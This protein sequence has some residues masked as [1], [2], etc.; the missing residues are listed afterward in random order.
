MLEAVVHGCGFPEV[1]GAYVVAADFFGS[2]DCDP[3]VVGRGDGCNA[4]EVEGAET[5]NT[6]LELEASLVK[7]VCSPNTMRLVAGCIGDGSVADLGWSASPA[8]HNIL[9]TACEINQEVVDTAKAGV[10]A[11][12]SRR[13]VLF[14]SIAPCS[15]R[16]T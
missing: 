3:R 1:R 5:F 6:F 11:R 15:C 2:M 13:D 16:S 4:S 14:V 8:V 12:Y 10:M 7:L 9:G